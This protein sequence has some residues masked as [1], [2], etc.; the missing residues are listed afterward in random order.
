MTYSSGSFSPRWRSRAQC[1]SRKV[2]YDASQIMLQCAPPSDSPEDTGGV[3]HHLADRVVVALGVV[4]ERQHQHRAGVG[5]QHQVVHRR[6]GILAA[7]AGDRG[8]GAVG[9][10]L[11]VGWFAKGVEPVHRVLR[12][13]EHAVE[14]HVRVDGQVVLGQDRRPH[15]G[16]GQPG[17]EF[18]AGAFGLQPTIGRAVGEGVVTGESEQH[19]ERAR[20]DLR[21]QSAAC[22]VRGRRHVELLAPQVGVGVDLDQREA[23]RH[24]RSRRRAVASTPIPSS[25]PRCPPLP[26][27]AARARTRHHRRPPWRGR[28]R[29]VRLRPRTFPV[30]VR[31]PWR[32]GQACATTRTPAHQPPPPPAPA[33]SWSRCPLALRARCGRRAPPSRTRGRFRARSGFRCRRQAHACR[34][35]RG[36]PRSSPSPT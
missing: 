2:G 10:G 19:P 6:Q 32:G 17:G 12:E 27:P 24:C 21:V 7:L 16:F 33:G 11:V 15:G 31:H 35:R 29:T 13:R 34:S 1:V 3:G 26:R 23:Q 18:L 25:A 14:Q 28:A 4:E 22:L 36:I 9:G 5:F 30:R 20:R 8:D